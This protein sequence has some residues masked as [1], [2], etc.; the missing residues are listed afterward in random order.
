MNHIGC[1]D[2]VVNNKLQ[3]W[4]VDADKVV[5]SIES[6]VILTEKLDKER[7]DI[8]EFTPNAFCGFSSFLDA[9]P[10]RREWFLQDS[11]LVTSE[12]YVDGTVVF[13]S[14]VPVN[15]QALMSSI[16]TVNGHKVDDIYEIIIQSNLWDYTHYLSQFIHDKP[17]H[18]NALIDFICFGSEENKSAAKYFDADYYFSLYADIKESR[19]IALFHYV[20][21]GESEG[22]WPNAYFDPSFYRRTHSDLEKYTGNLLSHYT[23]WGEKELRATRQTENNLFSSSS[24]AVLDEYQTWCVQNKWTSEKYWQ[25]KGQLASV[26]QSKLS[27]IMPVYNPPMAF[28]K[29]ALKTIEEQ[30]YQEWELC[31]ADDCSTD[32]AVRVFLEN[33]AASNPKVK[34]CF[35][36]NNGH[37]SAATNSAVELASGEF[38]VFMDQDDELTPDALAEIALYLA[39]HPETDVL[40]SDDDKNDVSGNRFA[41]Q[42]KPEWS[43]ELLL[44]YMYMSHIFSVRKDL[45]QAVGGTRIGYEGSQDYDLALRV[46][47]KAR[48]IGHIPKVLYHWR[49][50]PGSTASSGNDKAYSF[51]AGIKAVQDA[52]D[53]RGISATATQPEWAVQAGCGFYS[54]EFEDS[55]PSVAI[56]IPMKNQAEVTERLLLSL[57]N[58]TYENYHVYIVD[59]QSDEKSAHDLFEKTEHTV[60]SIPNKSTSFNYSYIN[61][62]AVNQVTEEYVLFLNNDTEVITANWLSQMVGYLQIEGVGAVGARLLYPDGSVQHAGV[63]NDLHHGLPGHALKLIPN[64]D[65]GYMGFAKVLKNYSCVTAACLLMRREEFNQL[66]QFDED[67]F[68]VAYNDVD[69]CYRLINSG[70]RV[71]YAPTAELYHHEGKSRGFN[72]NPNEELAFIEKYKDFD[73]KYYNVNLRN[74]H[75]SFTIKGRRSLSQ[76]NEINNKKIAFF[77]HNLNLEGAPLQ[78]LDIAMGLKAQC[79]LKPLIISPEDGPLREKYEELNIEVVIIPT[80]IFDLFHISYNRYISEVTEWFSSLQVEFVCSNTILGFWAID[81][82]YRLNIPSIWLIHESE[83]PFSH[84]S[85]YDIEAQKV[86]RLC[87]GYAYQVVFVSEATREVYQSNAVQQNYSVIYNGFDDEL[88]QERVPYSREEAREKLGLAEGDVFAI[89]IGTV[90]ERKGQH[91]LIKAINQLSSQAMENSYFAIVGDRESDYSHE[92]HA[93]HQQLPE[94]IQQKVSI[95]Q[96]TRD[97][98][99]YYAAAD[100]FTC[101]SRVESF[102]RV[103]QEA[104]HCGLAIVTT[105]VFGIKEQV[106]DKVSALF[107]QPDDLEALSVHLESVLIDPQ[108]R[109][110]LGHCAQLHLRRLPTYDDMITEYHQ[111]ISEA[112]FV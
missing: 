6:T 11:I 80:E 34:V 54:H 68:S 100:I 83:L 61:N 50:L 35:R 73:E 94:A 103:I 74:H 112:V 111:L 45:Y 69:L 1:F 25:L 26:V 27:I 24:I 22:R 75:D 106:K 7:T 87:L 13:E 47:E 66:G 93:L 99:L 107:Y 58:T 15:T 48:H 8:S 98:G 4:C 49:V 79:G 51:T 57:E 76:L 88:M 37:I 33:Y 110:K 92:L 44:S 43:P 56:I 53:R 52:L 46:T 29:Q 78:L 84:L 95:V 62:E 104:M 9:M 16:K 72:D 40:Y 5:I 36:E 41:P 97:I 23:Y 109:N 60:F 105:P 81:L 82:A 64:Y 77:T 21:Q 89:M 102:P 91:D 12:F 67:N 59:N 10:L 85:Q 30:V 19:D 20:H 86:A 2:A 14:T 32:P 39:K 55:G 90:C 70:K 63:L 38:L 42:F 65:A 31:I 28:F 3:G 71:V 101:C 17:V 108:L 18:D 96:E